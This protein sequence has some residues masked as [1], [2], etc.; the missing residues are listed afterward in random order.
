M[1]IQQNKK[2]ERGLSCIPIQEDTFSVGYNL[3]IPHLTASGKHNPTLVIRAGKVSSFHLMKRE[4][5]ESHFQSSARQRSDSS[6]CRQ[7]HVVNTDQPQSELTVFVVW[8][9]DLVLLPEGW[10]RATGIK[11][12]ICFKTDV[13]EDK[14]YKQWLGWSFSLTFH[15][16]Y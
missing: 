10:L 14:M 3:L 5:R 16:F 7:L 13:P 15:A 8:L 12:C 1:E 2:G 4:K 6:D 9:L 11:Q